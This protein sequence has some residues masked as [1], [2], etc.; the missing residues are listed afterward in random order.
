MVLVDSFQVQIFQI[1]SLSTAD[2]S[3]ISQFPAGTSLNSASSTLN[4]N[5]ISTVPVIMM[6]Q[7]P[8]FQVS[9]PYLYEIRMLENH[10]FCG[11]DNFVS[12]RGPFHQF[13]V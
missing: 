1:T 10:Q 11:D 8:V 7:E 6:L 9:C 12:Q 2:V 4:W 3:G 13:E 5:H